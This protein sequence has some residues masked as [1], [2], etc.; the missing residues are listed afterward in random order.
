[1][2][3]RTP[4]PA[5]PSPDDLRA[6]EARRALDQCESASRARRWSDAL[7][8]CEEA[9]RLDSRNAHALTLLGEAAFA[10][11]DVRRAIGLLDRAVRLNSRSA[12]AWLALGGAR[13]DAGDR[14]GAAAAYRRYL[15]L[16]PEGRRADEI[17]AV[18][19]GLQ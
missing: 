15:E 8:R 5:A 2:T 4:S 10:T 3:P 11:D 17:R 6:A 18:L 14:S 1:P 9:V 12:R 7:D 19:E 16:T 13:Q